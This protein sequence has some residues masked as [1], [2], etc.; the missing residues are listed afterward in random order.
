MEIKIVRFKIL[1]I[2][3]LAS[4]S[5]SAQTSPKNG[6][7]NKP[8]F[9]TFC[10][11]LDLPYR[12][13][14]DGNQREA[15][16]PVIVLYNN[17]YW[18]FASKSGG[19]WSSNDLVHWK[20]IKPV[21]LPLEI[22]APTVVEMKGRLYYLAGDGVYTTD[23]P[24]K[25]IWSQ[26]ATLKYGVGD[27]ALFLDDDGRLY[28]YYG[29][30]ENK[31]LM[32]VELD[33]QTFQ[34]I[35]KEVDVIYPDMQNRGWEVAGDDNL[36]KIPGDTAI[37]NF[38]PWIEG[39][40]MNKIDGKYYL[41]Y[42]APGTQF[43]SYADGVFVSDSPLG[44]FKYAP[45]SPFSYKPTGFVTGV[46]HSATFAD[47]KGQFWHVTTVNISVRQMFER[48]LALFPTGVLPGGQL[49]T[50][51]YL[52]DYPQF[53]PGTV[54]DSLRNNSP[55]WMLL[56]YSKPVKAS[57]TLSDIGRQNFNPSNSFDEE[58][59]TWWAAATGNPGEWLE[60]DLTKNCRVN[61]IQINFADQGAKALGRLHN[62]GYKYYVEASVDGKEWNTIIDRRNVARDEPHHYVQ[63]DTPI[64]ARYIK[65]TNV[66]SPAGSVFSIFD[67][68]VFG[69][70]LGKLPPKVGGLTAK[71]DK[72]D[73][74]RASLSWTATPNT[75]F[76]IV[77][78]GIAPDR[79]FSNFQVYK[80]NTVN[81]NSLNAGVE[82]YFTVDAVNS[83]GITHGDKTILIK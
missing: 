31:P 81:I 12:F 45:Y 16:D 2:F 74:R 67:L 26:V 3:L 70:G 42:A 30:N 55:G 57:S 56:S 52:G 13:Q 24:G 11:P 19:Y 17:I 40:W 73:A 48:R 35:G 65:I 5:L 49:V 38:L 28:L 44:P 9:N 47:K 41:Q 66:H 34:P 22:Y 29:C 63:L 69:S 23:N 64:R 58:I 82:Y 61:A 76:Y 59:R 75:D 1:I 83:T 32:A 60:V 53:A 27:P 18:L 37:K 39:S 68:R 8:I 79:L 50:N 4:I 36:G 54:K 15:A 43:K 71:R 80:T 6:K 78:Y 20:F 72:M 14:L 10:N 46:G 33:T 77:R 62:D 7:D 25:G 21:G 51:T